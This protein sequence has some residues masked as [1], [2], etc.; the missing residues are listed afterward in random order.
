M[1]VLSH[2]MK[3]SRS[4]VL[5]GNEGWVVVATGRLSSEGTTCRMLN[6]PLKI[7]IEQA[8]AGG[9]KPP[10]EHLAVTSVFVFHLFSSGL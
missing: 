8:M 9:Q 7:L 3:H 5:A 6:N 10:V 2:K 1:K 4:R